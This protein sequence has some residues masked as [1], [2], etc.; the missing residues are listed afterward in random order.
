MRTPSGVLRA[1]GGF[2]GGGV[3]LS[4]GR[5]VTVV[6][7]VTSGEARPLPTL[8]GGRG[9]HL[10]QLLLLVM[11]HLID[12]CDHVV[13]DLLELL[14]D[15]L[16]LVFRDVAVF[17]QRLELLASLAPNIANRDAALLR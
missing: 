13:G 9:L 5:S 2:G 8:A 7:P 11:E 3:S 16:Q 17:L 14:L 10:E 15:S 6:L 12:L 1:G 4:S